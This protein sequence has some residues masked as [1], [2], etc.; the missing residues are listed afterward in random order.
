MKIQHY[1]LLLALIIVGVF[2]ALMW[3]TFSIRPVI[4][5]VTEG[6]LVVVIAYLIFF[7]RKVIRPIDAL[8]S[9]MEL[10][11]DQ[12]LTNRTPSSTCSLMPHRWV[13]SSATSQAI[14]NP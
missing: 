4:F 8:T 14:S 11:R 3:L 2:A 13:S 5:Y 12:D 9:G 7:Y 6:V 1:F 10:L